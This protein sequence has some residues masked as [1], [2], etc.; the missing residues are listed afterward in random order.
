MTCSQIGKLLDKRVLPS[1]LVEYMVQWSAS[2]NN[3]IAPA[4]SW[5]PAKRVSFSMIAMVL[6]A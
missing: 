5:V 2:D 6:L 3:A 1:G 4:P